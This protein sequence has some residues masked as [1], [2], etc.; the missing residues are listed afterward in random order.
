MTQQVTTQD[1]TNTRNTLGKLANYFSPSYFLPKLDLFGET[2][3]LQVQG[4]H[5]YKTLMGTIISILC[6]GFITVATLSTIRFQFLNNDPNTSISE[7]NTGFYPKLNLYTEG[8]VPAFGI[9]KSSAEGI[10]FVDSKEVA[11]YLTVRVNIKVMHSQLSEDEDLTF[12]VKETIVVPVIPCSELPA[13]S[14]IVQKVKE[15][16]IAFTFLMKY[17]L[18]PLF[19]NKSIWH[20]D[21]KISQPIFRTIEIAAYPCSLPNSADCVSLVELGQ[22]RFLMGFLDKTVDL[23]NYDNPIDSTTSTD[24][25]AAISPFSTHISTFFFGISEIYD[26]IS[27][28]TDPKKA[29]SFVGLDSIRT[30]NKYRGGSVHCDAAKIDSHQCEPYVINEFKSGA[31]VTSY[32]RTYKKMV[33]E[34]SQ[35]GGFIQA[36]LLISE[37]IYFLYNHYF[38]KHFQKESLLKVDKEVLEQILTR[39]QYKSASKEILSSVDSVML[40]NQRGTLKVME[41]MLLTEE[42]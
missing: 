14:P 8:H 32:T 23:T 16:K 42:L 37:V 41:E 26:D 19:E 13:G 9:I 2:F 40:M 6:L 31:S 15:D 39:K 4:H 3:L 11:R 33:D 24:Y 1:T 34:F 38:F 30:T 36:A 10:G 5:G 35:L 28:F 20:V 12:G 17:S 25:S 21:G 7:Q 22:M 27:L 29:H 18:C